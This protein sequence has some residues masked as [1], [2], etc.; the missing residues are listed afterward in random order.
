MQEFIDYLPK[1][2]RY[3]IELRDE[4]WH[5]EDVYKLFK[6][7]KIAFCLYNTP[8]GIS[9]RRL[10]TDFAYVRLR[11]R[12]QK[13]LQNFLREWKSYLSDSTD[14][15]YVFFDNREEKKLAF[16]NALI[17]RDLTK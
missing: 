16:S 15:A 9:P 6:S 4:S 11:G 2:N 1:E 12:K 7:N 5:N 10:T 8:E 3:A 14:K 17:F 13:E